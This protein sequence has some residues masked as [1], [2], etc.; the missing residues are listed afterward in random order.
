MIIQEI[1]GSL[2]THI[3][4]GLISFIYIFINLNYKNVL[5]IIK[6]L[7]NLKK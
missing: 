7:I 4:T 6:F 2:V 1:I 5:C 3:G